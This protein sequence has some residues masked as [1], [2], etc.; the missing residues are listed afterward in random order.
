MQS[1]P[2]SLTDK[3]YQIVE[4][5]I[6]TLALPPGRVFSENELSQEIQIGRTPLR[7]ALQRLAHEGLV[8]VMPRR[9]MM[10]TEIN[11]AGHFSILETRR[12]IDRLMVHRAAQRA[13][14]AQRSNLK[15]FAAGILIAAKAKDVDSFMRLDQSC[16]AEIALASKNA[17]AAH[18]AAPLHTLCR[19]FWFAHQNIGDLMLSAKDHATLLEAIAEGKA[20]AA[21][22]AS[23]HLIDYLEQ[24]T[25]EALH[26]AI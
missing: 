12:V 21:V 18:A 8:R 2:L 19:R 6:V 9:G 17:V 22:V 7:E 5:M 25:R 3:A 23:D 15:G 11:A 4:E 14:T 10:I 20:E 26:L 16:D 24:F 1:Q 13:T